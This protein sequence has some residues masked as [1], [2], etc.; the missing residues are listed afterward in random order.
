MSHIRME[1]N[2][3]IGCPRTVELYVD[4]VRER[5]AE[6]NPH[7]DMRIED[8]KRFSHKDE[9]RFWVEFEGN[10]D[11]TEKETDYGYLYRIA[12]IKDIH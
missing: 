3:N 7:P 11:I 2:L 5:V 1:V 9:T 4:G 8:F 6:I 12:E 10:I